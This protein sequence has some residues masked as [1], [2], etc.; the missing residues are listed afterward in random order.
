MSIDEY[1][2]R[3]ELKRLVLGCPWW[4]IRVCCSPQWH[5]REWYYRN[6]RFYCAICERLER[7]IA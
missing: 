1:I 3:L 5:R 6:G 2:K 4:D 7:W